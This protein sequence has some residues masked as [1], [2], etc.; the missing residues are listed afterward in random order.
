MRTYLSYILDPKD[1]VWPGEPNIEVTQCTEIKGDCK[2]NS[3]LSN[4]PNHCGTHYDGPWHFNPQGVK[5]TELPIEYFWFDKVAVVDAPKK[6]EEGVEPKDLEPFKEEIAEAQLL[7]IKTGFS[8]VRRDEPLVYQNKGPYISPDTA[9][10][11][12]EN[13]PNLRTIGFDFLS[14]GS[15]CNTLSEESHQILLGC[16]SDHFVTGIEDMDLRPLYDNKARIKQVIAAPLR[17]IGVD[18]SQVCVMAEFEEN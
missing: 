7:L 5:F 11:L 16:H 13:F 1:L 17:I 2:Y 6:P 10:Y 9:R 4:L 14:I 15:P 18:S 3:F 12:T 8:F